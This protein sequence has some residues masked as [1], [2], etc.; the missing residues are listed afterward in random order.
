MFCTKLI[1]GKAAL[2]LC[3][4]TIFT[5]LISQQVDAARGVPGSSDFG[6]GASAY[7]EGPYLNEAIYLATNLELDWLAIDIPWVDYMPQSDSQIHFRLLDEVMFTARENSLPVLV[8]L[9]RPPK[10][11]ISPQGPEIPATIR[12][13]SELCS[14]YPGTLQAIEL[15]PG[16]NTRSGWG[17]APNAAGYSALFRNVHVSLKNPKKPVHLIAG[18]LI[19]VISA[20][21]GESIN[22][23]IFLNDLYKNGAKDFMPIISLQLDDV[24][25]SPLSAPSISE[26]R[27]LRHYEEVRQVMVA[28]QHQEGL[29][30]I[31]RL[32]APSGKINAADQ[33]WQLAEQQADWLLQAYLQ[34][35]SQL[36]IGVVVL[37]SLNPAASRDTGAYQRAM[38]QYNSGLHPFY[39]KFRAVIAAN[40]LAN[41]THKPI[42]KPKDGALSKQRPS[43]AG[44]P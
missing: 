4:L 36:Y 2:F 8:R 6:F 30:W 34:M 29:I 23:I 41:K 15:F 22:D 12:F 9:T 43:Q 25:G 5:S 17:T 44:K 10:W 38:I 18:G 1:R 35:R 32:S 42:G 16:A 19:P 3:L 37:D 14:R 33:Q 13:I 7:L 31:T 39:N 26:P 11:A 24:T 27:T 21:Q 28:N 40:S 20:V